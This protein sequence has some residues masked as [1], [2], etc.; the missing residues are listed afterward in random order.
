MA[1]IT[2]TSG[3]TIN[4]TNGLVVQIP[5]A[6]HTDDFDTAKP[7]RAAG[8]PV[9]GFA[10]HQAIPSTGVTAAGGVGY[11]H[12]VD[13]TNYVEVGIEVAS[14]FYPVWKILPGERYPFRAGVLTYFA[15][16]NTG[17]VRL[18]YMIVDP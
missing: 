5:N 7:V 12:N 4:E 18:D 2:V 3:I 14:V 8:S 11:W 13:D 16:A 6:S 9:I 17:S 10:T 15:Q 1:E